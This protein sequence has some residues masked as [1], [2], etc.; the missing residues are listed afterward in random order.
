M[1]IRYVKKTIF[2]FLTLTSSYK[3]LI[4]SPG[5]KLGSENAYHKYV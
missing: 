3:P 1:C 5:Y 2:Y 4:K